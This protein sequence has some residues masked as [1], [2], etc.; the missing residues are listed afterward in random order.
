[1]VSSRDCLAAEAAIST[2]RAEIQFKT[3]VSMFSLDCI[4]Q[5]A[6]REFSPSKVYHDECESLRTGGQVFVEQ[7]ARDLQTQNQIQSRS[8]CQLDGILQRWQASIHDSLCKLEERRRAAQMLEER[9]P[10]VTDPARTLA[11]CGF[12]QTGR[13][14]E[15]S[16]DAWK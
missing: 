5:A 14:I 15:L 8:L 13:A 1:M 4:N 2:A 16:A 12:N 3:K 11:R 7:I 10:H 9:I 6:V